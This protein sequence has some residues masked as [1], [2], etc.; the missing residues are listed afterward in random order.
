M[1]Q[2]DTANSS[3]WSDELSYELL[4][5]V[6]LFRYR[7]CLRAG[8]H[9]SLSCGSN[10]SKTVPL[11]GRQWY[12]MHC[13]ITNLEVVMHVD[14][15]G[16]GLAARGRSVCCSGALQQDERLPAPSLNSGPL[17]PPQNTNLWPCSVHIRCSSVSPET[18]RF[19]HFIYNACQI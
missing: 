8:L 11:S 15:S 16:S 14:V 3:H 2:H 13:A 18:N 12:Y 17:V 1:T 5:R 7:L 9:V 6:S 19:S 4:G 10:P